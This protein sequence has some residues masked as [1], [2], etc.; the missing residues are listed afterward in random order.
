[1]R[2]RARPC[3]GRVHAEL[4]GHAPAEPAAQV[5]DEVMQ[6]GHGLFGVM[7]VA[8]TI[9]QPEDVPG[10]GHVGNQGV[11][12]RVL[13]VMRVEAPKRPADRRAGANHRAVHVDRQARQIQPGQRLGHEVAVEGDER[14]EGLLSELAQPIGHR[15]AGGQPGQAAEARHEGIAA[16]IAQVFQAP[17]TDIEQREQHQ[18]DPGTAVVGAEPG[19]RLA[20]SCPQIDLAQI[21]PKQ[22]QTAVRGEGLGDELDREFT[23][24]HPSQARYAQT[25]QRGLQW[26]RECI[27]VLS[28]ETALEAPLIHVPRSFP[29]RLFADWG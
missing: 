6:E 19:E 3:Q 21:A 15:A 22:F 11:V 17:G 2:P 10:L 20:Q 8:G 24:D 1:M 5:V 4:Q 23:L 13:P 29:S 28:L 26:V 16:E 14:G 12:A 18:G 25:H 9:L 27:G 7:H